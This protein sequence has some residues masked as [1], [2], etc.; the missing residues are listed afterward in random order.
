MLWAVS[1]MG[2]DRWWRLSGHAAS[3]AIDF[4]TSMA[5]DASWACRS[6]CRRTSGPRRGQCPATERVNGRRSPRASTVRLI[7]T[8]LTLPH[9][10]IQVPVADE[11]LGQV[12]EKKKD[13]LAS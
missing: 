6:R 4:K 3:I 9:P 7:L 13:Q 11:V 5:T 8:I 2:H 10:V 1:T 12:A